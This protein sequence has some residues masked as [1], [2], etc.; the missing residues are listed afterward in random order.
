VTPRALN[1]GEDSQITNGAATRAREEEEERMKERR[2]KEKEGS[3]PY[4]AQKSRHI[5]RRGSVAL[6]RMT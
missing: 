3:V 1:G 2:K 4:F 5:F 6:E